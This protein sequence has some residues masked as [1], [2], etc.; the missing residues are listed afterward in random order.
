M[1]EKCDEI[2]AK[3]MRYKRMASEINDALLNNGLADLIKKMLGEKA[4]LHPE[5]DEK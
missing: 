2:D 1:C 3:I 5:P 4:S